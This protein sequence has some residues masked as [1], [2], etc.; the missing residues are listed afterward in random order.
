MLLQIYSF[1]KIMNPFMTAE[2]LLIQKKITNL[3]ASKQPDLIPSNVYFPL[4]KYSLNLFSF[5]SLLK[6]GQN[7]IRFQFRFFP[8]PNK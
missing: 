4:E 5:S 1:S 2:M 8:L 7:T 3:E 6:E